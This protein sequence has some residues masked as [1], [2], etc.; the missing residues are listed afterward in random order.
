MKQISIIV[1]IYHGKKY[2]QKIIQ[3]AEECAIKGSGSYKLELLLVND[4]PI[5]QLES[6]YSDV[7]DIKV[8][9]T[10][11]NRGIHASRVRGLSYSV[12]EY[13]LF[14]DQD[15][16]IYPNYFNSQM[17]HIEKK[18]AVVC[19]LLHEG[20]QFYD[21]RMPFD[22]IINREYLISVKNPIIS[23]GQ[24]L[25][26]RDRIP[27]IWKETE[28]QNN[29]ADD[30]LL[31]LCMVSENSEFALNHEILFEHIVEGENESVN[32]KHMLDSE[33]EVYELIAMKGIFSGKEL[34]KLHTAVQRV[35]DEHIKILC[36]FQK[37]FFVYDNWMKLQECDILLHDYLRNNCISSVAIYGYSYIGKRLFNHLKKNGID[38]LYFIDVNAE[39]LEGDIPIYAPDRLLPDVD[40][41]IIS[42]VEAV[43][44]IRETISC[45]QKVKIYGITELLDNMKIS[46]ETC[47]KE[48][49]SV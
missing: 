4:D 47:M 31:W 8:I 34:E 23:P 14:L 36:K 7:L 33:R 30:W 39:Y 11:R 9:E 15:D 27:D 38:V 2:I 49:K 22:D 6:Y 28:L 26:R 18:A 25:L 21:T 42:L 13:I 32:V 3:Q 29:G 41:V 44:C 35:T 48:E 17:D 5:N 37:M 43:D 10:D 24:V 12:G 19:K 46:A 40:M 1:P 45:I 16:K 20:R